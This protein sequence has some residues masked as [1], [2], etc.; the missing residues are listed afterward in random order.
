LFLRSGSG[1]FF[2]LRK[3]E[4]VEAFDSQSVTTI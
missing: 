3:R 1:L 4:C 2:L